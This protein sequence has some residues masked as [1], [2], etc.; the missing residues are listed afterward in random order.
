VLEGR[1]IQTVVFPEAEV[2]IFLTADPRTRASR[3]LIE[4]QHK[5]ESVDLAAAEEELR[6]RDERDIGRDTSPLRAAEDAVV[7]ATDGI[8]CDEVVEQIAQVVREK[9]KIK[10]AKI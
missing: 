5:G 10:K 7:V 9:T 6:A 2:K 8:S 1:D 4:W 3:R